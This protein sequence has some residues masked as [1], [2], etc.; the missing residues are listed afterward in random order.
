MSR[1][2]FTFDI[3]YSIDECKR[4]AHRFERFA[5]RSDAPAGLDD[6]GGDHQH[7]ANHVAAWRRCTREPVAISMPNSS[8]PAMPP[9]P[10]PTA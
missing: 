7:R 3:R 9:M 8:G 1:L 10:V 5:L 4:P 6:G 2:M